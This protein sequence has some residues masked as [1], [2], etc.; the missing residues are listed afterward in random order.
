MDWIAIRKEYESTNKTLKAVA[1]K[2]GIKIGTIKSRK[3]R[4]GWE[5]DATLKK[6]ATNIK[7]VATSKKDVTQNQPEEKA[8]LE[9]T[10]DNFLDDSGLTEKQRLFCLY[11]VRSFNATQSAIN[12]GYSP[13]SA[14]VEGSR[15]LKNDKVA[16]HIRELKKSMASGL[17]IEAMD[18]LNKYIKIAFS[19]ITDFLT[20][21]QQQVPV[22]E[23]DKP[24]FDEHG[25][26]MMQEVNYVDFKESSLVDGTI[27]SEVKQGRNGV[28][29]RLEDRMKALEKLEL[30]FVLF[31]DPF[32]RRIEEERLN[33]SKRKSEQ[34]ERI[35]RLREEEAKTKG[36]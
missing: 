17:F 16:M 25:R 29:I 18:V 6:D 5:K 28:S 36:W 15:L 3:S 14:H 23:E 10:L 7:K 32:K 24:V 1:E 2:H 4:E 20:F 12:A 30:Y 11:Y 26:V 34:D 33:L 19:D 31:P 9:I 35:V 8:V 13:I 22:M 27:I 21:G